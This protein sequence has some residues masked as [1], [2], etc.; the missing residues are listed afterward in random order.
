MRCI[1]FDA[2][3]K[4][5]LALL[6]MILLVINMLRHFMVTVLAPNSFALK[7]GELKISRY[8]LHVLSSMYVPC[9]LVDQADS[10]LGESSG[11]LL[12]R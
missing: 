6:E 2:M 3:F 5:L 1:F 12:K 9:A 8:L 4:V 7:I 11:A 10:Q